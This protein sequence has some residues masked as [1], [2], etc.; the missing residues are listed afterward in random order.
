M[1][2]RPSPK[3]TSAFK[4]KVALAALKGEN[5]LDELAQKFDV[6]FN[7]IT[8]KATLLQGAAGVFGHGRDYEK[9]NMGR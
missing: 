9:R 7:Q 8:W 6:H 3:H 4:A 2:K 5:T 1:M